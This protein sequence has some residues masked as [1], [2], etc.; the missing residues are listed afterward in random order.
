MFQNEVIDMPFADI[1]A[2][3]RVSLTL[4]P[5]TETV[6]KYD[7]AAFG[8]KTFAGIINSV[9]KNFRHDA[10][11][12][13]ASVISKKKIEIDDLLR[14]MRAAL[15]PTKRERAEKDLSRAVKEYA[16]KT[17]E[18]YRDLKGTTIKIRLNN[19]N[20]DYLTN[21]P[22]CRED[23]YYGSISEYIRAV[24]EEY[25][26]KSHLEREEIFF[27]DTLD[28]IS[29]ALYTEAKDRE[30]CLSATIGDNHRIAVVPYCVVSDPLCTYRYLISLDI[31]GG[32]DGDGEH[33]RLSHRISRLRDVKISPLTEGL[34][35]A[36]KKILKDAKG[37]KA[38]IAVRGAQFMSYEP[39]EIK[40]QLTK[41]GERMYRELLHLK[42]EYM[43]KTEEGV[44]TFRCTPNQI[45]FFFFK[46]GA[47]AKILEP[48]SLAKQFA[49]HYRA[50]AKAYEGIA[51][52][53]I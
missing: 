28:E 21:D 45:E 27:K 52:E 23:R 49:A 10:Q 53:D 36:A 13:I 19:S 2:E 32:I 31:S 6:L 37:W 8:E 9:F 15:D 33:R 14:S 11:A 35:R 18:K 1:N 44:Y 34:S 7:M 50:A 41:T 4:S 26:Q 42:P 48:L 29:K 51:A 47:H 12:S 20:V 43:A 30:Y 25:A 46:F 16:R 3:Q 38:E 40:V 39:M 5:E 24:L 17:A 22:R